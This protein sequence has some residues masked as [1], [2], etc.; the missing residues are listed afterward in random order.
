MRYH[1]IL[2]LAGEVVQVVYPRYGSSWEA[3][4]KRF[5]IESVTYQADG[6]VDIVAKEYDDSFYGIGNLSAG[7]SGAN[8]SGGSA[9][10][11]TVPGTP[12]GLVVTSADN[13]TELY[14]G[15]ELFWN[16]D[17]T[18]D[19]NTNAFTE[20]YG[21]LSPNL[22]VTV[23]SITGEILTTSA[24]HGL[25]QGMTVY[26]QETANLLDNTKVYF[27]Y[28]VLSTTTFKLSL[29]RPGGVGSAPLTFT[30]GTG[31]SLPIRTATLL[32][33]VST[34]SR[35]YVDSIVNEGTNRVEK[36]Y[37]VRHKVLRT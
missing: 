6:L 25:L 26:P 21:G 33:S 35:S 31:L 17:P 16:N 13:V 30:T 2:L 18:L 22:F 4:G 19:T 34:P 28:E 20:V 14:N 23:S 24:P 10:V 37:W 36:Y 3:P 32:T 29:V 8:V 9:P 11:N 7:S 12:T 5:R 27:V 1:G 15:V